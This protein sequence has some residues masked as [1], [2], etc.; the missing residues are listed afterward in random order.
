MSWDDI[1]RPGDGYW[2]VYDLVSAKPLP[3]P[4]VP[5]GQQDPKEQL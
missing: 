2:G 4:I 3:G 1:A 5:N